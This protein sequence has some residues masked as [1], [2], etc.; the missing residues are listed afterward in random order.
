MS[1]D[2]VERVK[3][4]RK[5]I[6]ENQ[7]ADCNWVL[8]GFYHQCGATTKLDFADLHNIMCSGCR[9]EL[10]MRRPEEFDPVYKYLKIQ[11]LLWFCPTE[12]CSAPNHVPGHHHHSS[13]A[14]FPCNC[15][16]N[17]SHVVS[18]DAPTITNKKGGKQSHIP[19]RFD[20]IDGAALFEMAKVLHE[21]AEKYGAD[22]WRQIPLEDHLNHMIMHAYAYLAGDRS[23]EHLSHIMCRATFAQAVDLQDNQPE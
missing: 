4:W 11:E 8:F 2:H 12:G 20:L 7:S 21:G 16:S 17:I 1:A 3:N 22:N 15:S 6:N 23:D 9:F 5:W 19:A 13:N 14:P 10:D 18:P